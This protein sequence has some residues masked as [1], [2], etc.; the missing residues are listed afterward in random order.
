MYDRASF[1]RAMPLRNRRRGS[2]S[3]CPIFSRFQPSWTVQECRRSS[4]ARSPM[5]SPAPTRFRSTNFPTPPP[6]WGSARSG[7]SATKATPRRT[8]C[9][10]SCTG[11]R[12][13]C[14]P[15][16]GVARGRQ[17]D[18]RS[19]FRFSAR[20]GYWN[21][22]TGSDF[23]RDRGGRRCERTYGEV[24]AKKKVPTVAALHNRVSYVRR[25]PPC[26]N[27]QGR[28]RDRLYEPH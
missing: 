25:R 5:P 13:T 8:G 28:C 18:K 1:E 20:S 4:L 14:A 19:R 7:T 24:S 22:R 27:P 10:M 21:V 26:P 15:V 11:R 17:S 6:V 16:P 12:S 9:T 2:Q 23:L 3:R